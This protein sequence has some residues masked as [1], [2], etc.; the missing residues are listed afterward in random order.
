MT[1][2]TTQNAPRSASAPLRKSRAAHAP[3]PSLLKRP[4][5]MV[6]LTDVVVEYKDTLVR[7]GDDHH[8][9]ESAMG[10]VGKF[11][12]WLEARGLNHRDVR[13]RTLDEY[14]IHR[15]NVDKV[16]DITR[17]RDVIYIKALM[18]LCLRRGY[19]ATNYVADYPL[20][21]ADRHYR[22]MPSLDEASR[23]MK[24]VEDKNKPQ[25]NPC[26]RH[27]NRESQKFF[28]TRDQGIIAIG[29]ATGMRIS[30]IFALCLEDYDKANCQ[31]VVRKSKPGEPR[32]VALEPDTLPFIEA[33]LKVRP[34][35]DVL[36]SLEWFQGV[37]DNGD[38]IRPTLFVADNGHQLVQNTWGKQFNRYCKW[39]G[40]ENITFHCLRH[41][42]GTQFI[43]VDAVAAQN[44][45][46]HHDLKVT[47][48]YHHND[49]D[50]V[51]SAVLRARPLGKVL[52]N[53]K[54]QRRTSLIRR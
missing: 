12:A 41:Y 1:L 5:S 46:G 32:Y 53:G 28:T 42:A 13:E 44:Q 16:G 51:R 7:N 19:I 26:R 18:K 35:E 10:H 47:M 24:A 36:R 14:V 29:I 34:H 23:L 31:L 50:H 40:V 6:G 11:S 17:R 15:M 37:D 8:T 22:K 9:I 2:I 39:A 38:D 21:K 3:A 52:D 43:H 4:R 48:G 20:P 27:R 49:A 45:L 33:W 25:N 30:E 54:P